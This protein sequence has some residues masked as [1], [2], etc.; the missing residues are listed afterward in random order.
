MKAELYKI[1]ELEDK[2]KVCFYDCSQQIAGDRYLVRLLIKMVIPVSQATLGEQ[3]GGEI[4]IDEIKKVL[5][6]EVVFEQMK[7]RTFIDEK[8][9]NV[10]LKELYRSFK[11]NSLIYLNHR[12]FKRNFILKLFREHKQRSKWYN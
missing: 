10:V 8:E 3:D 12:Y 9:K 7:A 11:S 1:V 5:G 2:T 6:N 4:N